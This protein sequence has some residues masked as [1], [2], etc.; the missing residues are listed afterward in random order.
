MWGCWSWAGSMGYDADI[1]MK[2][3]YLTYMT[4]WGL[5]TLIIDVNLQALNAILHIRKLA[6]EGK[7]ISNF[8]PLLYN[9]FIF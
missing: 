8:N 4:N 5:W 7:K 6:H 3:Y 1:R 9:F 2:G